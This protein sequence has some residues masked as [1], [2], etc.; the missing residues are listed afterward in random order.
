MAIPFNA[1]EPKSSPLA[2]RATF[3]FNAWL[4]GDRTT[5]ESTDSPLHF[6]AGVADRPA[7]FG[8]GRIVAG[9]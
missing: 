9:S 6:G 8:V 7:R 5:A 3:I 2:N 4:C 1:G